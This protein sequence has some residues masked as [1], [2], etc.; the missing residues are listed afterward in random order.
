MKSKHEIIAPQAPHNFDFDAA[1]Q[2]P[3]NIRFG[4]S[5]WN[6]PG[7]KGSIYHAEYK[8]D[9]EFRANSLREYASFPWFR[10]VGVDA[11]FY[12][13]PSRQTLEKY[14]AQVPENFQWASKVWEEITIPKYAKH[15]RY[16]SRAG[17][18]NE[19]FLN[20]D[21]F[22]ERV[23][24]PHE[25]EE[26]K[27]HIGPFIFEFQMLGVEY[28]REP[29][30]F[31]QPLERFLGQLPKDFRYSVEMRNR[32]LLTPRYFSLLNNPGATHCFNH[33]TYM[34]PLRDQMLRA[35]DAGGLTA[36]FF[37]ARILTPVGMKYEDAVEFYSPYTEVKQPLLEMRADVVRL[38]KRAVERK[39]P[40]FVLVN[41]RAEG[42]APQT[43][44]AVG[45]MVVD[46][47]N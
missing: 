4:T 23:L 12:S 18:K 2:L 26:I 17:Q 45:S 37:I 42:N 29:E 41:N 44:D 35:S 15:A 16:G 14:S 10:S 11:F 25:P 3:E 20:A 40:V 38:A 33:W 19:N 43:I 30:N 7:W 21:L 6:Y 8:N 13:P 31:Y 32:D 27:K 28:T 24:R 34:P 22:C 9:K 39:I 47:L 5:S 46:A 36:P 1:R